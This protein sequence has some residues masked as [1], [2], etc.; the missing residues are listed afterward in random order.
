MSSQDKSLPIRAPIQRNIDA[1]LYAQIQRHVEISIATN[2]LRPGDMVPGEVELASRYGVSRV[3]V[4]QALRELATEGLLYRI[5][6]KGT[7]VSQPMIQRM[8][9]HITSFFYEM[10]QSGRTPTARA[11]S[12][13]C[14][15]D[16]ETRR[17]LKLGPGELVIVMRRLRY[18]DGEPI[19]Y[20]VNTVREELCPGL[21]AEDL[22]KQSLQ[23]TLEIKYNVRLV[24]VEET[25]TS[26]K[27]DE[28]LARLLAIPPTVPVLVDSRVLYGVKGVIIGRAQ[29]HFRGDRYT[30]RVTRT[31][32]SSELGN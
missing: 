31:L 17:I 25:L 8:E 1:P 23:Y 16:P 6:G 10:L 15:P 4:R 12:E 20:Q 26:V 27:P 29:A 13:V 3:T 22:T 11:S 21:A 5:Q 24:E 14:K 19:V 9:P 2:R 30:Y 18:V 7:F 32:S 28:E